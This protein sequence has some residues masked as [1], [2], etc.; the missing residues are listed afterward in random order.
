MLADVELFL[1]RNYSSDK[2]I[3]FFA[4]SDFPDPTKSRYI[5]TVD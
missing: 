4:T 1:L 3:S 5:R 2:A